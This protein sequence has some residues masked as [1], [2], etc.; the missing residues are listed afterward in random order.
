MNY[1]Y[2]VYFGL[3]I[4]N[5]KGKQET[6]FARQYLVTMCRAYGL[7]ALDMVETNLHGKQIIS[8]RPF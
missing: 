5:S 1:K 4:P 3:A 7:A 2:V 8:G 6:L